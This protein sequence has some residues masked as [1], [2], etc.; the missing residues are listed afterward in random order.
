[1]IQFTNVSKIYDSR[2]AVDNV[3]FTIE[4]GEFVTILGSSGS[5]KTTIIKMINRL[6]EPTSGEIFLDGEDILKQDVIC[7]RRQI[8]YVVQQIGLFPHMTVAENI[9][10]VPKLLGWDE[11]RI[12]ARTREL[13]TLARLPYE[14][15]GYRY[16]SEL[17]GGQQQRIGVVRALSADPYLMLF[18]EPFGAI[19]AITRTELQNELQRIHKN[20]YRKTF[21]FVTHD[22]YE[23]LRLGTRVM[24]L[25]CGRIAQFDTPQNIVKNPHNDYV[26]KLIGTARAQEVIWSDLA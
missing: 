9:A 10:T 12:S 24:I 18:D 3:S 17:S 19:D 13:M 16:P 25:E 7:L 6:I 20:L 5:G 1:M 4:S 23:A 26:K 11:D 15:Y 21:V 14:E 2:A 8:G 22:I